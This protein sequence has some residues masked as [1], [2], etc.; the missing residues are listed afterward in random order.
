[1][2]R[3]WGSGGSGGR[4]ASDDIDVP[5]GPGAFQSLILGARANVGDRDFVEAGLDPGRQILEHEL[6][7]A[8]RVAR[9]LS[10]ARPGLAVAEADR[11]F[12]RAHD[13]PQADLRWASRQAVAALRPAFGAHDPR[14]L[15]V[16]EDLLQKAWRDVLAL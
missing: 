5:L 13:V 7:D 12:Q 16:L 4:R 8:P 10:A 2:W 6:G 9:G 14:A 3:C 15:E 11:P 1:M